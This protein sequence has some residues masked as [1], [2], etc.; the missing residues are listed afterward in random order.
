MWKTSSYR[1]SHTDIHKHTAHFFCSVRTEHAHGCSY[2]TC[3]LISTSWPAE[4]VMCMHYGTAEQHNYMCAM[5]LCA[6]I[7][8]STEMLSSRSVTAS[9]TSA[10]RSWPC[11]GTAS[12]RSAKTRSP[13]LMR[14]CMAGRWAQ[15]LWLCLNWSWRTARGCRRG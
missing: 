7:R 8:R 10:I 4:L 13:S 9:T 1:I 12:P 2:I 6:S 3:C 15:T 5:C 14:T 11:S